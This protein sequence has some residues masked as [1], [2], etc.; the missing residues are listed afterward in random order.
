M[1]TFTSL[2]LL[3]GIYGA[4]SAPI[5][6]ESVP[7]ALFDGSKQDF[8]WI[9]ENDPVMGGKSTNC[10]FTHTDQTGVFTGVVEDVPS[11]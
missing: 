11:L 5:N 6:S 7:L 8:K 1:H 9:E 2:L 3:I 4:C 10:T